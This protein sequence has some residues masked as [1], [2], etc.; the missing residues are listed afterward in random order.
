M[1]NDIT[2][3]NEDIYFRKEPNS[4]QNI[5]KFA[6]Y[7]EDKKRMKFLSSGKVYNIDE[8]ST[9][10]LNALG[11]ILVFSL[12]ANKILKPILRY[13]KRHTPLEELLKIEN[14]FVKFQEK[15]LGKTAKSK[16]TEEFY[17]F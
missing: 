2:I 5:L 3:L 4:R 9:P 6:I 11:L 1:T 8:V 10:N 17:N 16:N 7:S 12:K 14:A 13:P 15:R